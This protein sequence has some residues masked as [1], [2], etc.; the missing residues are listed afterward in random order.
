[1]P[2][3]ARCWE[4]FSGRKIEPGATVSGLS[5]TMSKRQSTLARSFHGLYKLRLP[6]SMLPSRGLGIVDDVIIKQI[7]SNNVRDLKVGDE[8][9]RGVSGGVY[10]R[11]SIDIEL[12]T[13]PSVHILDEPTSG[14]SAAEAFTC[15]RVLTRLNSNG[16]VVVFSIYQPH[17]NI[18][19]LFDLL[20]LMRHGNMTYFGPGRTAPSTSVASDTRIL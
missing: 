18:Y 11:L 19:P 6:A 3:E 17:S 5:S 2:I 1:M 7:G 9:N 13:T 20:L 12:V 16:H 10:H 8:S 15:L 4:H 14:L